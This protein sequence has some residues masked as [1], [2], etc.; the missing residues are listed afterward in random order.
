MS[1]PQKLV[2]YDHPDHFLPLMPT[3]RMA[4]LVEKSR[5]VV[6]GALKLQGAL[7]LDARDELRELVRAMNSYYSNR[8][9][10]Q[11][12][13]PLNIDR[14]LRSD[15]SD[16]PDIAKRQRLAL[17]HIDAEKA[18]EAAKLSEVDAF[19][20]ETLR[21]AHESLYSRLAESD[22]LTDEGAVVVPGAW[23]DQGVAV[24][25]HE[26]PPATALPLFLLRADEFYA[27][28]WG[29]D[30]LLTAAASA[31]HRLIWVHPFLDGNGRACRLQLHTVLHHLTGGLWSANRGLARQREQYYVRLAEADMARQGDLDGRGNLSEKMLYAWCEFFIEVCQD[32]VSF[33]TQMLAPEGLKARLTALIRVRTAERPGL[34]YREEAILPLLHVLTAGPVSRGEFAQMTGLGATSARK[35]LARLLKDGLLKSH[36]HVSVVSI[37]FP[38]DALYILLPNLYPEAATTVID[39]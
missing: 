14:A 37:G 3:Q 39:N 32:Q 20:S 8:I 16:K 18:L 17:A 36:S 6:E 15:F 30:S 23:R 12:T 28:P 9:E 1:S 26:P 25:R 22:R 2:C 10:G 38:L 4:A 5:P 7:N 35:V 33:M 21:R 19:R 31:H 24:N 11:S 27:R 34:G 29:L 13:H